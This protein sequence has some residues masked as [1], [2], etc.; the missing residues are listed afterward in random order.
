MN[1]LISMD[2]AKEQLNVYKQYIHFIMNAEK[3]GITL[4]KLDLNLVF[5]GNIGVGKTTMAKILA[6]DLYQMGFLK[7][8][9]LVKVGRA[10]LIASDI[11][12]TRKKT[13]EKI[14]EAK[15]GILYVEDADLL[16][17]SEADLCGISC[18]STLIEAMSDKKGKIIIIFAGDSELVQT[19]LD[20]NVD[21]RSK[22][23]HTFN[24]EK[25]SLEELMEILKVKLKNN[26][27]Q[28]DDD[29]NITVAL[30]SVIEHFM[31]MKYFENGIFIDMLIQ[32]II[33]KHTNLYK[34]IKKITLDSI[35]TIDEMIEV[36]PDTALVDPEKVPEEVIHRVAYHE[37]GHAI[38]RKVLVDEHNIERIT[39]RADA[40]GD[41]GLVQHKVSES[42]RLLPT[43]DEINGN[44]AVL[45]AGMVAE[46]HF[47]GSHSGG[48]CSDYENIKLIVDDMIHRYCMRDFS[49]SDEVNANN[50]MK[51]AKEMAEK[52]IFSYGE[53]IE[54]IKIYLVMKQTISG[55]ELDALI[56]CYNQEIS[57]NDAITML[58]EGVDNL[59]E[60]KE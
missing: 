42:T 39:I 45:F 34:D 60:I 40:D 3:E 7:T 24:F 21:V 15:D 41:L 12:N 2:K 22:I 28:L 44:L 18:I 51:K 35:P 11:E 17:F 52:I 46:K 31:I 14:N 57:I 10:D 29:E 48:C 55:E 6:N 59:E 13:K 16:F 33:I 23:S 1:K 54:Y 27:L 20:I 4:P 5:K 9:K 36:V 8:R 50:I 58:T 47:L 30:N 37:L 49:L 43:E 32:Q 38:V 53:V 56:D 26:G 19:F 25:Y